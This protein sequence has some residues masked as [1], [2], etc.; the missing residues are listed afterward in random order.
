MAAWRRLEHHTRGAGTLLEEVIGAGDKEFGPP[1]R[2][3]SKRYGLTSMAG[4]AAPAG[5]RGSG[6]GSGRH[7]GPS[8]ESVDPMA[9]PSPSPLSPNPLSPTV[10]AERTRQ[11]EDEIL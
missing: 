6:H 11:T 8:F 5:G 1:G 4:G 7:Q 3:Q 10:A 2:P 9:D